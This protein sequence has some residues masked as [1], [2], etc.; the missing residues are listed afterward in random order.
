MG[1]CVP[2]AARELSLAPE[3]D[4]NLHAQAASDFATAHAIPREAHGGRA[5]RRHGGLSPELTAFALGV[6]DF[7]LVLAAA[8]PA[9]T[10]Y[11]GVMDRT[12]ADPGRHILTS[13][14]AATLFVGSFERL[15]GYS[16]KQLSRLHWQLTRVVMTWGCAVAVLLLVAFVS[17]TSEA[18]SRGWVLAWIIAAPVLLL[19]SRSLLHAAA[20]G[21][22]ASG[23]LTRNI[24]IVGA[25][26]EGQRLI[27][28]LRA[29]KDRSIVIRGVFDDRKSR[30]PASICG[31]AV[32]GTTDDLLL[33]GRSSPIDEV[34]IALPL[35]AERRLKSL[36]DKLQ[37]LAVDVRLS[38][39][40]L[41]ETFR[42]RAMG[43]VGEVPV[44]ELVD[45]P[46]KNWRAVAKWTEDKLLGTSM[47]IFAGP[48][49][50]LIAILIKLDSRGPV[51]FVQKRFGFNNEVIRVLKFRTMQVDRSDPSG[52][53][54][55]VRNDPRVTSLGRILRW[56]SFDELP[57]LINVVR[58][59]MSLVG[60]RPHAVAMKA[61]DRLYCEAVEHYMHRHR[62][63]PGITGLAQVNGLRGEIDTLQKAHARVADD[64]YYIEH[65]SLWLDLKIILKTAGL[66]ASCENAY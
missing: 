27:A 66:L 13:F 51:F 46:L 44:L 56:L 49:M 22:A 10:A 54:R 6:S 52:A 11:S 9:F 4:H 29:G 5:A 24:A 38:L 61:G 35:H 37:A 45:R 48:L 60:P 47:L 40:P 17:K 57:Q 34:V 53:R 26:D 19:I 43:Y 59:D 7:C 15:G 62:V 65:W 50:M 63:K 28:R 33:F 1:D 14:L 2:T 23:Y 32:R 58:G 39:E 21:Q 12:L 36:C 30:L 31:L 3:A 16:L 25:G 20:V 18:Y 8:A 55:T 42:V 64:L 41:A